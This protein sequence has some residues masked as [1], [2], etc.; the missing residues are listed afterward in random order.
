MTLKMM[1]E[2]RAMPAFIPEPNVARV[3]AGDAQAGD[4]AAGSEVSAH[5]QRRTNRRASG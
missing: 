4:A 3:P 5:S 2:Q 1:L